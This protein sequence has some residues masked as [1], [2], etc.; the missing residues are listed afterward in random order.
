VRTIL[1]HAVKERK[2]LDIANIYDLH[3]RCE[4]K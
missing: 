4:V 2:Q 3:T 1:T